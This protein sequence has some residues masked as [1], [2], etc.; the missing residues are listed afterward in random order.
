MPELAP[1]E[2]HCTA[3]IVDHNTPDMHHQ[4]NECCACKE[5]CSL[6]ISFQRPINRGEQ[7]LCHITDFTKLYAWDGQ[8]QGATSHINLLL[9]YSVLDSSLLS[10]WCFPHV[11]CSWATG[12]TQSCCNSSFDLQWFVLGVGTELESKARHI[13]SIGQMRL[14]YNSSPRIKKKV[15]ISVFLLAAGPDLKVD[16]TSG[17]GRR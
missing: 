9:F 1:A 17:K 11:V 8:T 10:T 3:T 4:T 12:H 16:K 6:M 5:I 15:A 7:V 14:S 13:S 2:L